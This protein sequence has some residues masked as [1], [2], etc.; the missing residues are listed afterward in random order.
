MAFS[1][2]P[3]LG[4]ALPRQ[5]VSLLA[6]IFLIFCWLFLFSFI[7]PAAREILNVYSLPSFLRPS[8][9]AADPLDSISV[10]MKTGSSVMWQRVPIHFVTSFRDLHHFQIYSDS[11]AS[12]AGHNVV[13]ALANCSDFLKSTEDFEPYRYVS[14]LVDR[15]ASIAS[16]PDSSSSTGNYYGFTSTSQQQPLAV[17]DP[18][19][20]PHQP[21]AGP[22]WSIDKF[23]N[24]PMLADAYRNRLP[25]TKWFVFLDADS[26]I[27]WRQL[28]QWLSTLDP[29]TPLY[30]GSIVGSANDQFAHGGSG[31]VLSLAA[32]DKVFGSNPNIEHMY[33]LE[34][35]EDCCGDHLISRVLLDNNVHPALGDNEYPYSHH[36]FQ[37][38]PHWAVQFHTDNFCSDI[39]SFHHLSPRDIEEIDAVEREFAASNRHVRYRDIYERFVRPHLEAVKEDWNNFSNDIVYTSRSKRSIYDPAPS[40]A[41]HRAETAENQKDAK[42]Y[43]SF[44]ACSAAC[45]ENPACM[46]F[47]YSKN[48]CGLGLGVSLGQVVV[49]DPSTDRN[50]KWKQKKHAKLSADKTLE[51]Q[52]MGTWTSGWKLDRIAS[53]L[54]TIFC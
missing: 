15:H 25:Q 32:M 51:Q 19:V 21:V 48:Y 49:V 18:H 42:H 41:S 16:Q 46:Q 11:P 4:L 23:K 30:M 24:L 38:E 53:S 20:E 14:S 8:T 47:R 2:H 50:R 9:A 6:F 22:N 36:K 13:D 26:Y 29:S 34:A 44:D 27:L 43:A 7:S 35:L 39:M 33:D 10:L 54:D 12:I 5:L 28:A 3:A 52:R 45:D 37:G 31:V 17:P 40:V 1:K